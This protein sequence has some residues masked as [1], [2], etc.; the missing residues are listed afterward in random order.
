M[1][2]RHVT[3]HPLTRLAGLAMALGVLA[4]CAGPAPSAT[5]PAAGTSAAVSTAAQPTPTAGA[6]PTTALAAADFQWSVEIAQNGQTLATKNDTVQLAR[7][8][9]TIRVRLP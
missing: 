3:V 7:S 1:N 2:R 9:F 6:V 4:A 8:A 5:A